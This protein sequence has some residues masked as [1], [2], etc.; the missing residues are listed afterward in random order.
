[1]SLVRLVKH[2]LGEKTD[3]TASRTTAGDVIFGANP[4]QTPTDFKAAFV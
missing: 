1:V 2:A 4:T 3:L